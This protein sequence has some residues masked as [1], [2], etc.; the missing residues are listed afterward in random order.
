MNVSADHTFFLEELRI[1]MMSEI[2]DLKLFVMEI[3]KGLEK[4][5][6]A[7]TTTVDKVAAKDIP[8]TSMNVDAQ[9]CTKV[10]I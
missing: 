2:N 1:G 10:A 3:N 8:H 9:S 5:A 4:L 6:T 7:L